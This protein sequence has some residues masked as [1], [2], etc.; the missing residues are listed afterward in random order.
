MA[1]DTV[2]LSCK[3][4]CNSSK[5]ITCAL[6]SDFRQECFGNLIKVFEAFWI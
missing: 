2:Q 5:I 4:F 6:V 3:F 1:R